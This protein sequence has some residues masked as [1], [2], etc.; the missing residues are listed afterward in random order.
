MEERLGGGVYCCGRLGGG[1]QA[2]ALV[3][4][5]RPGEWGGVGVGECGKGSGGKEG[6]EWGKGSR[7]GEGRGVGEG[8]GVEGEEKGS[9]TG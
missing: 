5:P 1:A 6:R 3:V 8:K 4:R 2:A 7:G 9:S